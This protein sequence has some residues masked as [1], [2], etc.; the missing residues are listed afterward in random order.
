[1]T[2]SLVS[3]CPPLNP[4]EGEGSTRH[5]APLSLARGTGWGRGLPPATIAKTTSHGPR[6]GSDPD[7]GLLSAR[8]FIDPTEILPSGSRVHSGRV[9]VDELARFPALADR[10][11]DR[12]VRLAAL[13]GVLDRRSKDPPVEGPA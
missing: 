5:L 2:L 8:G 6:S 7:A 9:R 1:M 12:L 11:A 4:C 13:A 10:V 3:N